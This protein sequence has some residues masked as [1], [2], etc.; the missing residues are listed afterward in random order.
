[1]MIMNKQQLDFYNGLHENDRFVLDMALLKAER[2]D[3]FDF[4]SLAFRKE[5]TV[6]QVKKVLSGAV[7][8]NLLHRSSDSYVGG[9][10]EADPDIMMEIYPRF[11]GY[12]AEF[13][14]IRKQRFYIR[15]GQLEQI[16]DFLF[17]LWFDN[18]LLQLT[19]K[20]WLERVGT[21]SLP[22]V[23]GL[24]WLE[25]YEKLWQ[26]IN[27]SLLFIQLRTMLNRTVMELGSLDQLSVRMERVLSCAALNETYSAMKSHILGL[28]AFQKGDLHKAPQLLEGAGYHEAL[29]VRAI[30]SL[31][32][33]E[34]EEAYLLFGKGIKVQKQL[35][36]GV[37][38]PFT[39]GPAF[40]YLFALACLPP[41]SS[42][43][44]FH[45]YLKELG[46]LKR[47]YF[48]DTILSLI[49]LHALD[50]K[51][52]FA[53][54]LS[55]LEEVLEWDQPDCLMLYGLLVMHMVGKKA[56][57]K[58][59]PALVKLVVRAYAGGFALLAYEAA[60]VVNRWFDNAEVQAVLQ[61]LSGERG[62]EPI[63]SHFHVAEEWETSLNAFLALG[64]GKGSARA[65]VPGEDKN[66]IVYWFNP[67]CK[68]IRPVLLSRTARG[69][70]TKGRNIALKTFQEGQVEGMTD[71]DRKIATHVKRR[72]GGWGYT[73]TY[74]FSDSVFKDMAGHPFIYL[75]DS[76]FIPIELVASQPAIEVKKCAGGYTL[77]T[78]IQEP[79]RVQ[80][81]KET[82]TRFLVYDLTLEQRALIARVNEQNVV[83]PERGKEKLL[84]VLNVF[85]SRM[86]VH[87]DA[88]SVDGK[89]S[90]I[91]TV[92]ADSRLRVQL[93]PLGDGLKVELFAKPFGSM[94]PYCKPGKGGKTLFTSDKEGQLQVIRNLTLESERE[95]ALL[96]EMQL[97]EGIEMGADLMVLEQPEACL[98]LLELLQ[99]HIDEYV[100]EW[101]EGVRYTLKGSLG[102]E[103]LKLRIK[104]KTNW[105]A[106]EGEVSVD[107][108]TLVRL[109]EFLAMSQKGHGRFV[110]LRKGE[111]FALSEQLRKRLEE[112][113]GI[114]T[115][116]NDQVQIHKLAS[117]AFGDTLDEWEDVTVDKGW[118]EFRN[119]VSQSA[120]MPV[121]LPA[122]LQAELR[123]YQEE[124]FVWLA[125]LASWEAGACLA[126]DMGLG[127]T[128]QALALL[129]Y[130]ASE[131]P[132]LV[133]C[134]VSVV[135]NWMAEAE[136][137]AP[138]L[139]MKRMENRG[140]E[141]LLAGLV[142]SDVLVISYGLLQSER[143]A[144]SEVRFSTI[145]LDEAH[146]IK[147]MVTKTSKAAM[148][149]QGRFRLALTGTPIQNHLGEIWNLFEFL[150]PGLLGRFET[151]SAR[152]VK[153]ENPAPR[154]QLRKLLAPFMLRRVK[155]AV[156]DELPPKTEILK[157]I[158]LSGPERAYY[159]ALRREAVR[160]IE[161]AGDEESM[162][163]RQL[164]ALAEITRLRQ[165]A[166]N[167][168]L[169]DRS[170]AIPSSKLAAFMDIVAELKEGQHRPLVF[171]Q[172][173]SH[174]ALV[175]AALDKAGYSYHYL[176]GSTP[177]AERSKMVAAFQKGNR[178]MFLISLKA[179]GLGLNLTAADY[180]VHLDPWWNPAIEDQASDRAHR[181]GQSKP[182][183]IYRLVA[184][185]TIE[186][187]I[188]RLH[189]TKRDLAETLLE[190]TDITAKLTLEQLK[191]LIYT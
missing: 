129:L 185:N 88:L 70:W 133:V 73:V 94:P 43:P 191:A 140:R 106:L 160:L 87:S 150:N 55:R 13:R 157:R 51:S 3:D 19:E 113:R 89:Q 16:A 81:V 162:G 126:D 105:F 111:F 67:S 177:M 118:K 99:L 95:S 147:N 79:D 63:L 26:R 124:G 29:F 92:T 180:V 163:A 57:K 15:E 53:N 25:A 58:L 186:E 66:R 36:R 155:S 56:N 174:L 42:A 135:P 2:I 39:W 132:A 148:S 86:A 52:R 138:S 38:V 175:R 119:R 71:Q 44:V 59:W 127:K 40:F 159:E 32:R 190:G 152:F 27:P 151:F 146:T 76:D 62:Y 123:P 31:S 91:R 168:A 130:R 156:L 122:G 23:S 178:D 154:K 172:F 188:L 17:G 93:L 60:Y 141:Q 68:G 184:E 35:L 161:E 108:D 143:K 104:S 6:K 134:P 102:F 48:S 109:V 117:V 169:V 50:E 47:V 77:S 179:G 74:D 80:L 7:R 187:K 114:G 82:N 153:D 9:K 101:P 84:Q 11:G 116:H 28:L 10:L 54:G 65:T 137:F 128:L 176:D 164:K 49:A 158:E 110:E 121:S 78:S 189:A 85:S 96:S 61:A 145:V 120:S 33:G 98:S 142:P 14:A 4:Q 1:M 22:D 171:S 34:I 165:A 46:K 125:R 75:E 12:A 170:I 41:D 136:R 181:I 72:E 100:V 149:L 24:F 90:N 131:G 64:V 20:K 115:M 183:T 83:V 173:V 8:L 37:S 103:N 107:E 167:P 112:V 21:E 166:C 30:E 144:L 97:L 182:V 139:T 69:N 18:A 45:K 5:I